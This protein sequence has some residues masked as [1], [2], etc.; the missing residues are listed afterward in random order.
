MTVV[1]LDK[2]QFEGVVV[3]D[4]ISLNFGD[5]SIILTSDGDEDPFLVPV[6]FGCSY[7]SVGDIKVDNPSKSAT[8]GLMGLSNSK[9]TFSAQLKAGNVI[10]NNVV[11]IC[12]ATDDEIDDDASG[13]NGVFTLFST[14]WYGEKKISCQPGKQ[15]KDDAIKSGYNELIPE[16][17]SP[18][19]GGPEE[20]PDMCWTHANEAKI[21]EGSQGLSLD[22]KSL[23]FLFEG[24][25]KYSE[26]SM[27]P[28]Q[29]F[30]YP[31]SGV[32]ITNRAYHP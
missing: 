9:I 5:G 3:K 16:A 17:L 29:Y 2:S 30:A 10:D 13:W 26:Y 11:G 12:M 18:V 27:H 23:V 20:L 22:F 21:S 32:Q 19:P 25:E 15:L 24:A 14:V 6:V 31:V 28:Q 1:Y 8:D 7:E 4:M